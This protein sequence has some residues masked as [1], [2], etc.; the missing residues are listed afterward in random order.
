LRWHKPSQ[1]TDA[2]AATNSLE[3][4]LVIHM[5]H[6]LSKVIPQ[7]VEDRNNDLRQGNLWTIDTL[8]SSVEDHLRNVTGEEP[9]KSFLSI[10]K[11]AEEKRVLNRLNQNNS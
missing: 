5:L 2:G 1:L 6:S 8:I 4:L 7:W 10:A 9:V 11:Q 3:E